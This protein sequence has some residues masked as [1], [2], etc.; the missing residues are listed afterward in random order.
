MRQIFACISLLDTWE[1]VS[2]NM[3]NEVDVEKKYFKESQS[4]ALKFNLT[5]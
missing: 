4:A 5:Y 1:S 3:S 2:L